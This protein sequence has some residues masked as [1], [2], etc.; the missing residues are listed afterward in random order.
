MPT[1]N[2]KSTKSG[3]TRKRRRSTPKSSLMEQAVWEEPKLTASARII[4]Q[5]S[6]KL[7]LS[8]NSGE[9]NPGD[10]IGTEKEIAS[11]FNISR[12]PVRDALHALQGMGMLDIRVGNSGGVFIA[13]PNPERFQGALAIQLQLLGISNSE[14]YS[15]WPT[16]EGLSAALAVKNVTAEDIVA[17]KLIYEL[18]QKSTSD[19]RV[20]IQHGMEFHLKLAEITG[21][22]MLVAIMNVIW[23][24]SYEKFWSIDL[25]KYA[26]KLLGNYRK[27]MKC[28]EQGDAETARK[29]AIRSVEESEKRRTGVS[30]T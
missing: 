24:S 27:I 19:K 4:K 13:Q 10:F 11:A 17:L 26:G 2:K 15:I 22:R 7:A 9:A 14:L 3:N 12:I 6:E 20:F 30:R 5:L 23:K 25:D 28:L 8:L 29:I 1:D 18:A 16:L 21:N